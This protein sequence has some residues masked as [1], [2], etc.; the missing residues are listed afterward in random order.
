MRLVPLH[1]L[2]ILILF[3]E[4][5]FILLSDSSAAAVRVGL[6]RDGLVLALLDRRD[7]RQVTV[8]QVLRLISVPSII[9]ILRANQLTWLVFFMRLVMGSAARAL[10]L[11]V[12]SLELLHVNRRVVHFEVL[13]ALHA[14]EQLLGLAQTCVV[15]LLLFPQLRCF[16]NE[17]IVALKLFL[18]GFERFVQL[19][20]FL[21]DGCELISLLALRR[22]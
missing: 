12:D 2:P 21:A 5:I 1:C 22:P 9:A 7:A 20:L 4:G 10:R 15:G 18:R 6:V 11:K 13:V 19:Y 14:V 8:I 3:H 16:Q 17:L